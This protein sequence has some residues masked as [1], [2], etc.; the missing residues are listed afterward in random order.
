MIAALR[1]ATKSFSTSS[2][3]SASLMSEV[4]YLV[5]M[6]IRS[7]WPKHQLGDRHPLAGGADEVLLAGGA[8][9]VGVGVAVAHVLQRLF[10]AEQL[11]AGLDVDFRILFGGRQAGVGVVVAAVDVDVDAVDR[12]DRA[13]EAEEVD[14]DDVVDRQAGQFLDHPQGQFR[15]AVGVG[16]VELVGAEAGDFDLEVARD[17]HQRDRVAVGVEA[18]QHRR[19]RAPRVFL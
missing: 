13:D 3:V 10:P 17:R 7:F 1:E 16:G 18:Q 9:Q 4:V 12:V 19:V 6:S 8:D 14:V 2:I 11:V 5:K 15:A